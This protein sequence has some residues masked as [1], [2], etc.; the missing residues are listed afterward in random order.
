M[1]DRTLSLLMLFVAALIAA[2]VLLGILVGWLEAARSAPWLAPAVAVLCQVTLLFLGRR[3]IL[4]PDVARSA[5]RSA[6]TVVGIVSLSLAAALGAV[7]LVQQGS[8]GTLFSPALTLIVW[9]AL[10]WIAVRRQQ[11]WQSG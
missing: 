5:M 7:W 2:G 9:F 10:I 8:G 11:K 1:T 3:F 6:V 4:S